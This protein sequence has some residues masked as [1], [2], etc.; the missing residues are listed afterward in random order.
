MQQII[1]QQRTKLQAR[2]KHPTFKYEANGLSGKNCKMSHL[3]RNHTVQT[4]YKS[5]S[6]T[7]TQSDVKNVEINRPCVRN[8]V[9]ATE[10][11]HGFN[12]LQTIFSLTQRRVASMLSLNKANLDA[13]P[14]HSPRDTKQ[15]L[16]LN[17]VGKYRTA[18][19]H[20]QSTHE[21]ALIQHIQTSYFNH[22][23]PTWKHGQ[24]THQQKRTN[25]S[26]WN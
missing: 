6:T 25:I 21:N 7:P 16:S 11:K 3:L 26:P 22:T 23:K 18:L 8:T 4:Y 13:W 12:T 10:K 15:H 17:R 14:N 24:I 20:G 5:G 2:G 1:S 9:K 19:E